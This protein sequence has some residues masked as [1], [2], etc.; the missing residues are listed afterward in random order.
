MRGAQGSGW[1]SKGQRKERKTKGNKRQ[2]GEQS[3]ETG[4]GTE[5]P[6]KAKRAEPKRGSRGAD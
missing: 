1:E 4:C 5:R 2:L 3:G 6:N